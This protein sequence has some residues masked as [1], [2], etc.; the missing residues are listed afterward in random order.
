MIASA[1]QGWQRRSRRDQRF[2][3]PAG[4]RAKRILKMAST[5]RAGVA[6]VPPD[7]TAADDASL[8][9][10]AIDG[11]REA[12]DELVVRHRRQIYQLCHRM[13]GNHEDASDLLQETFLRA[14][15]GIGGFRGQSAVGTWLYRIA[16]NA[17]LNRVTAHRPIMHPLD[18]VAELADRGERADARLAGAERA[19]W[20]RRA[21]ARLP[22]KQ[23]ATLVL[24]VYHELPHREIARILG[25]SVGAVKANFFHALQNMKRLLG[26]GEE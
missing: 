9:A 5:E 19:S 26:E 23:R 6:L 21:V 2:V 8:M 14:Y 7:W 3:E 25:S 12:F 22:A 1:G 11:Q 16:V 10:A 4:E 13:T 20:V 15:R 18:E 17:C 24:R